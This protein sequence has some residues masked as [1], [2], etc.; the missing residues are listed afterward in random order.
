MDPMNPQPRG[1]SRSC[2][3]GGAAHQ[4]ALGGDTDKNEVITNSDLLSFRPLLGGRVR[5]PP[6]GLSYGWGRSGLSGCMCV[7]GRSLSRVRL[8]DPLDGSPP[9]SSV[10]GIFQVTVL[11]LKA[12]PATEPSKASSPDSPITSA[13]VSHSRPQILC[14]EFPRVHSNLSVQNMSIHTPRLSAPKSPMSA[15]SQIPADF[16]YPNSLLWCPHHISFLQ[17]LYL[18]HPPEVP[19]RRPACQSWSGRW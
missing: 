10:H 16:L 11:F 7:C 3:G 4:V 18:L 2:G 1:G 12:F 14:L 8:C 17:P 15:H 6:T 9:G 13:S 5:R 19:H